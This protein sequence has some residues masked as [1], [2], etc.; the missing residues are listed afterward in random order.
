MT[1]K[2]MQTAVEN[3]YMNGKPSS[4]HFTMNGEKY[5]VLPR[6]GISSNEFDVFKVKTFTIGEGTYHYPH[7]DPETREPIDRIAVVTIPDELIAKKEAQIAEEKNNN[8]LFENFF[9][10][11][12][13]E[14]Y[15][16]DD[17]TPVNKRQYDVYYTDG[18]NETN[19]TL[20]AETAEEALR[21]EQIEIDSWNE[22]EGYEKYRITKVR[23]AI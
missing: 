4:S 13:I 7:Y 16:E 14:E 23:Y 3:W 15:D 12:E 20:D 1:N 10:E 6:H 8:A 2:E 19:T 22:E 11:V 18:Q 17:E 9:K 5:A 21:A